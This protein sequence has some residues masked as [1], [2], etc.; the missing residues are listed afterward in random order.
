MTETF[1]DVPVD[2]ITT[3]AALEAAS[4]AISG[5]APLLVVAVNP[6]KVIKAEHDPDLR[7]FIA[8]AGLRIPDGVGLII[9]SRLRGGRLRE[10]V[11]GIDL[12]LALC[13]R[14]AA[15][16]WRIYLLGARREVVEDAAKELQHRFPRITIAGLRDGY[17]APDEAQSVADEVAAARTDLLFV[18]LGSP[19][20]ENFLRRSGE[21]TGARVLM[22]VGGSFDVLA[23]RVPRAPQA[24]RSVGLEWLYRLYREPWRIR[25]MAALPVFLLR[26]VRHRS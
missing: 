19:L 6:E 8:Q 23:G 20:Q 22:G 14:A 18:A 9:A 5:G 21:R 11:T 12:F 2:V 3:E 15:H 17:F 4:A 1:L 13:E 7:S 24:M 16:G 26:T 25:R 10:R